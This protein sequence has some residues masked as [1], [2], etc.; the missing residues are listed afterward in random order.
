MR[1]VKAYNTVTFSES[2]IPTP[3]MCDDT[4]YDEEKKGYTSEGMR[5]SREA[6]RRTRSSH[7]PKESALFSD[8]KTPRHSNLG[9]YTCREFGHFKRECKVDP[10]TLHLQIVLRGGT[11]EGGLP[12]NS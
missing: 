4:S 6:V 2:I 5:R 12:N 10:D 7:R 11:C 9:C 3:R 8:Q 1:K